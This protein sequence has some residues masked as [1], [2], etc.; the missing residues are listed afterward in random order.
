MH[1]RRAFLGAI[2]AA[3]TGFTGCG[4][5]GPNTAEGADIIAGPNSRL[6][7]E[8]VELTATTGQTITWLFDSIGHNVSAI[9]A[10]SDVVSLPT[11]AE[12]FSSYESAKHRTVGRGETFSHRFE[13]P[14]TYEYVCIPHE[15][16]GMVGM[17]QV[18][19]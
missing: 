14:G 6:V 1:R 16:A 5:A 15:S 4:S 19:E 2:A 17:I 10:H 7:F 18:D 8:P 3:T 13:V 9:P 11:G 12:P